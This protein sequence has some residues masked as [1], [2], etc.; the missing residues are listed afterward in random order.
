MQAL[1]FLCD[2]Y[3]FFYIIVK[4]FNTNYSFML[5]TATISLVSAL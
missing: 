3:T 5:S 4:I 1:E 2:N